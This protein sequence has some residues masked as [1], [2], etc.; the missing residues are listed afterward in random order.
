MTFLIPKVKRNELGV[1]LLSRKLHS[2]IFKNISFPS[3]PPSYVQISR[4]HLRMHGLDPTQ[5]SVLPDIGFQLPSLQGSN[6]SEHFH[7]IG[8]HASEPWLTI[9]NDFASLQLPPKPDNWHIQSGWTKYYHLSNGLSYSEHVDVPTHDGKPENMLVFDVETMPNYHPYAVM[10]CAS[11]GNA[12][13]AWISPWLLGESEDPQQLISLGDPTTPRVVVGHNVS[14]DRGR[15]LEE[16][17]LDPS[18]NRFIDT[19]ALH[20]A[21][22]GISSHQRPA[23]MKYRK[24]KDTEDE[25]REEAVEAVKDLLSSVDKRQSE[26]V[27]TVKQEELRRLRQ[28]MEDS[29]LLLQAENGDVEVSEADISS[30]R[31]EELTSANSLADVAKLHCG[32]EMDKTIRKDFMTSDSQHIRDNL[33][34]YLDYCAHDVSVTHSVYA[35]TLPA[36]LIACPHPISFAGI[37]TMGSSFLTVDQNWESYLEKAETVYRE[38]EET[39]ETKLRKLAEDARLLMDG[40][41]KKWVDDPWLS[42]LD[43]TPKIAGKSRGVSPIISNEVSSS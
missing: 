16:Y 8:A 26:E 33:T 17:S 35:V 15:V 3:P 13:Y 43:W 7:R 14:Y 41:D 1:Q 2:Q 32:I 40:D 28:D 5:G 6:I 30:K 23:W 38:M 34:D 36:F 9:A 29:L 21:V 42:Q 24:L 39:V 31:W 19:M 25:Q 27:D 22:S 11:S 4:D 18:A 20:V 37:L 10:A 12:W